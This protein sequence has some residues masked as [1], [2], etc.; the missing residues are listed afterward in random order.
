MEVNINR[1]EYVQKRIY[2]NE[3]IYKRGYT[4]REIH[5]IQRKGYI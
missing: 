3:D 4:Q 5:L 1:K 2:T